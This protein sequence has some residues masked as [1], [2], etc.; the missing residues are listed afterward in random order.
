M[1]V[2]HAEL[3]VTEPEAFEAAFADARQVI[4]QA[5]GFHWVELLRGIERPD[6]YVLLVGWDSVEAHTIGF[7]ES[8]R[9]ARWRALVGPYFTKPPA[10]EHLTICSER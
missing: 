4:A 8:P 1:I 6:R 9:F 7:R 2:E 3:T 5:D 10:V